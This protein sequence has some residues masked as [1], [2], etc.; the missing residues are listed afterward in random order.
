MRPERDR[1]CLGASGHAHQT[2]VTGSCGTAGGQ[3]PSLGCKCLQTETVSTSKDAVQ[4]GVGEDCHPSLGGQPAFSNPLLWALSC[5]A[6]FCCLKQA[7][8]VEGVKPAPDSHGRQ[9][10]PASPTELQQQKAAWH[11]PCSVFVRGRLRLLAAL[12]GF[13]WGADST[14]VFLLRAC[15]AQVGCHY[16][17]KVSLVTQRVAASV[18]ASPYR[19]HYLQ[20]P[21]PRVQHLWPVQTDEFRLANLARYGQLTRPLRAKYEHVPS[22]ELI[23]LFRTVVRCWWDVGPATSK[24]TPLE[25]GVQISL[26]L[27]WR[28]YIFVC[29][30][31]VCCICVV[32][33]LLHRHAEEARHQTS[34]ACS[35]QT[36]PDGRCK[37]L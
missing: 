11:P 2:A 22:S 21:Y 36:G 35:G 23:L 32:H 20:A 1:A 26:D 14:G 13:A 31:L 29:R 3:T 16:H 9:Q 10:V 33:A 6:W 15:Q 7:G 34:S 8:T 30:Q 28:L 25:A 17:F 18:P 4:G 27:G 12:L 5:L 19:L 37:H 24:N